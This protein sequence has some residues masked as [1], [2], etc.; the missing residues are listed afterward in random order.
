M[1]TSVVNSSIQ[2]TTDA[3]FRAWGLQIS[4]QLAAVGLTKTA[5]SGQ[6]DF[7]T[8]ARP[9]ANSYA[10]YE[11]WR[12]NDS[13]QS[14][15]PIFFKIEYGT[16][17]STTLP[18][19]AI[20]V[21]T[22]SNGAGTLTG[23]TTTRQIYGRAAVVG[24][25]TYNS[26]CCYSTSVGGFMFCGWNG[27]V[28]AVPVAAFTFGIW[29]TCDD[30]G[31]PNSDGYSLYI[32]VGTT[33]SAYFWSFATNASP[34]GNTIYFCLVPGAVNASAFGTDINVYKHFC[35]MPRMRPIGGLLTYNDTEIGKGG[36]FA[37]VTFGVTSHT[38]MALGNGVCNASASNNTAHVVAMLWE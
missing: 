10:G 4:T 13:L 20:T 21:G 37:L 2:H 18:S 26:Y 30:D 11:I 33:I 12:F 22:G 3:E 36:T 25:P 35:S 15:K 8:V 28:V 32:G 23:I 17:T 16:G 24:T 9:G 31:T 5:D 19:M 38:F 29:R 1:T 34:A 6:I 7:T 14:T 27:A